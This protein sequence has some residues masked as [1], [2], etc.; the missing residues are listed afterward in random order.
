MAVAAVFFCLVLARVGAFVTLLPLA[1]GTATPRLVKVGLTVALTALWGTTFWHYM[2]ACA[3]LLEGE[4]AWLAVGVAVGREA[5]LGAV[6]GYAFGLFLIPARIAGEFLTQELGL[7]LGNLVN[8]SGDGMSTPLAVLLEM[9]AAA[10]FWGLDGHHVFFTVMHG[11]FVQAP[12]GGVTALPVSEVLRGAVATEEWGLML[13]VPLALCMF[14]TTVAL[15][16][17]ARVAPQLNLYNFGLPMR[18]G[19]GLAAV[20]L[21]LPHGLG[22]MVTM[23]AHWHEMLARMF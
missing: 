20:V 16:L 18:L 21:L 1:G 8:A 7:S 11:V 15:T 2:P 13:A 14:L 12:V 4:A 19:L 17:M 5:L 6:I 10:V 9:M 3:V 23:F 22:A